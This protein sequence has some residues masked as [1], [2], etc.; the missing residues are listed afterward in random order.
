[1]QG[2]VLIRIVPPRIRLIQPGI[3][4]GVNDAGQATSAGGPRERW[5]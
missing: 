3:A 4:Y 2:A 1:M 5:F